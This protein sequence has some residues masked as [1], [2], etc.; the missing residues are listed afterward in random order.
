MRPDS[1]IT[2]LA[3]NLLG[4]SLKVSPGEVLY[5]D[6]I[7]ADTHPLG[8]E[9]IRLATERG[10]VPYWN[11]FDDKFT[12]PFFA[13]AT[14]AQHQ[15]FGAF[16]KAIM[17]RVDAY[18]GVRAAE[19]P[20]EQG[21][22]PAEKKQHQRRYFME[23]VHMRTRLKKRWCVLRWPNSAMAL[24]AKKSLAAF[25]DFYFRVCN[26][27]Y[28]AMSRS[29]DALV[30]RMQRT[31]RVRLLGQGTD[32]EFSIRGMAAIKC[33]GRL[34]IP[35]G[36]VYTA[37]VKDSVNGVITYNTST[38]YQ[39]TA[40][41][42]LRLEVKGGRITSATAPEN[43]AQL[44]EIL[45]SDEGARSFGEFAIGVNPFVLEPMND[46][47]FDEKIKGSIHFTPGNAYEEC[48]NGNRSSVHWDLV[49]IQRPE[50][51][52]G[53]IWFDD[54]LV[55][56]DGRFVPQELAGLDAEFA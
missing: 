33:D 21:D 14:E 15:A 42:D 51:G 28:G 16:H 17:E 54:E 34:N 49:L 18:V 1:R 11:A 55:R 25:E 23:E 30:D 38:V 46:A 52:G 8:Q 3:Q 4:Y 39:G 31:D 29:M 7:G 45:D 26:L 44:R 41:R 12:K 6:L 19:N 43:E 10:A 53:E 40:F 24:M 50:H 47:L 27:D 37:P 20:F 48:D 2:E 56:K 9:L 5:I 22:L 32:I 13:A 35:D 36:E